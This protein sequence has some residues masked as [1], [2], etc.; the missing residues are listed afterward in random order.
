MTSVMPQHKLRAWR[1]R[2]QP[3]YDARVQ[4]GQR[5]DQFC[6]ND[7]LQWSARIFGRVRKEKHPAYTAEVFDVRN[8]VRVYVETRS[9]VDKL[10]AHRR[11]PMVVADECNTY[12]GHATNKYR[13]FST[14][15]RYIGRYSS[16]PSY[17][18]AARTY[19]TCARAIQLNRRLRFLVVGAGSSSLT[20][21]EQ[22]T[23][24][25]ASLSITSRAARDVACRPVR[26]G[27]SIRTSNFNC[28]I[29]GYPAEHSQTL[30]LMVRFP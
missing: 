13:E 10:F 24:S 5:S 6:N 27:R 26:S 3:G 1:F 17:A 29:A 12:V 7:P 19:A 14:D 25:A 30:N 20:A 23:N 11:L 21:T 8:A 22:R 15:Q 9:I 28:I 2:Q 16:A 4:A 18:H